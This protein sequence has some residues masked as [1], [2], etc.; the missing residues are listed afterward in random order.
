MFA[1]EV[2]FECGCLL[3]MD[4]PA[5]NLSLVSSEELCLSVG[6]LSCIAGRRCESVI[7]AYMSRQDARL[8]GAWLS[9]SRAQGGAPRGLY[10]L[11]SGAV[12]GYDPF[13]TFV[14]LCLGKMD[15]DDFVFC[16]DV[17]VPIERRDVDALSRALMAVE[18]L[19]APA[20]RGRP[21]AN[22]TVE[23]VRGRK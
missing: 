1:K 12:V 7:P 3:L 10:S 18:L 17:W 13:D 5:V 23:R 2:L 14:M 21:L 20:L 15:G 6:G 9:V 16:W 22:G 11:A 8:L 19:G 4:R